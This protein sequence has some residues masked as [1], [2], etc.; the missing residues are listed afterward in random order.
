MTPL[1]IQ[2]QGH[3]PFGGLAMASCAPCEGVQ[4]EPDAM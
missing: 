4:N 2:P 3:E 1:A